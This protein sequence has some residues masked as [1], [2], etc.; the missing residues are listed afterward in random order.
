MRFFTRLVCLMCL[1]SC[2][3][4]NLDELRL[5]YSSPEASEISLSKVQ[6]KLNKEE[7]YKFMKVLSSVRNDVATKSLK[8]DRAYTQEEWDR[9]IFEGTKK[10]LDGKFVAELIGG[11]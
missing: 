11:D 10:A 9:I 4:P 7:Y 8:A 6:S 1:V 3:E 2:N 5:D